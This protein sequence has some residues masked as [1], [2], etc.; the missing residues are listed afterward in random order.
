MAP[1]A[2]DW[3]RH[4]QLLLWNCWRDF[5]ET[6]QGARS[7]RPLPSLC[8]FGPIS[9]QKYL[10]W[11]IPQKDG[12]LYSGA[13]YVALWA[14]CFCLCL[15]FCIWESTVKKQLCSLEHHTFHCSTV[16]VKSSNPVDEVEKVTFRNF[17]TTLYGLGLNLVQMVCL[18]YAIVI[19]ELLK[20]IH[21]QPIYLSYCWWYSE[22]LSCLSVCFRVCQL[23]TFGNN[24]WIY[25]KW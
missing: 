22:L 7:Q 21:I 23:R 5:N 19:T 16:Q 10:P 25:F 3:L 24:F 8:F 1:V 14:S 18:S 20:I 11:P 4:F 9:K 6:W 2:S 12:T 15:Y 13:R 17:S